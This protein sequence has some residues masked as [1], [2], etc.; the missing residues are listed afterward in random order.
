MDNKFNKIQHKTQNEKYYET[1]KYLSHSL[2]GEKRREFMKYISLHNTY[3]AAQCATTCDIDEEI[4]DYISKKAMEDANSELND[5]KRLGI[6]ALIELNRYELLSE[7]FKGIS[8]NISLYRK[9]V[10]QIINEIDTENI[11][12]V[13]NIIVDTKIKLLISSVITGAYY[14]EV[15][16]TNEQIKEMELIYNKLIEI[17][18]KKDH[19]LVRFILAFNLPKRL[20]PSNIENITRKMIKTGKSKLIRELYE[21]YDMKFPYDDYDICEICLGRNRYTTV[22][23]FIEAFCNVKDISKQL[24][25]IQKCIQKGGYHRAFSLALIENNEKRLFFAEKLGDI[26]VLRK[27]NV[28]N[29]KNYPQFEQ[30][31]IEKIFYE[32]IETIQ[33]S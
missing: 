2:K 16:L 19:R 24:F 30:A 21:K 11:I 4:E 25:L 26:S 7:I 17:Y 18:N 27:N 5:K 12:R 3:L 14:K 1:L 28:L 6:L 22:K 8:S 29:G 33:N 13:F 9:V 20:L 32:E 23:T 10:I 15:S 31:K